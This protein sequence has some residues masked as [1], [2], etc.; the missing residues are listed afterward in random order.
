MKILCLLIAGMLTGVFPAYAADLVQTA[1]HSPEIQTFSDAI[2]NAGLAP[3]LRNNGPFTIFAPSDFAF[4]RLSSNEKE[5]LLSDRE[6]MEKLVASHVVKGKM[7]ITE[8]K[9]GETQTLGGATIMLRSDNGL[10]KI[11]EASVIQSDVVAD[12]GVIHVIDTVVQP[13]K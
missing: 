5:A 11:Q 8:V 10:V 9:P 2:D 13:E 12:N 7:M 1:K 3:L 4:N 6:K